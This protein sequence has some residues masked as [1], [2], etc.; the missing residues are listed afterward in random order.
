MDIVYFTFTSCSHTIVPHDSEFYFIMCYFVLVFVPIL[1]WM[2][3]RINQIVHYLDVP[4]ACCF[5]NSFDSFCRLLWFV[6]SVGVCFWSI[7]VFAHQILQRGMTDRTIDV[8]TQ[9]LLKIILRLDNGFFII[10]PEIE[11]SW[12]SSGSPRHTQIIPTRRGCHYL[13][14]RSENWF[15]SFSPVFSSTSIK[16]RVLNNNFLR[17][18]RLDQLNN[19]P[20]SK[21]KWVLLL[22]IYYNICFLQLQLR[23]LP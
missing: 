23:Y 11:D 2:E 15:L 4:V 14:E 7:A 22:S 1:F 16:I 18:I 9:V 20:V 13:K 3:T 5:L 10:F 8:F 6:T 17:R 19:L 21:E 12:R